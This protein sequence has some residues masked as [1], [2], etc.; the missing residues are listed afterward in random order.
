MKNTLAFALSA[1]RAIPAIPAIFA[2]AMLSTAHAAPGDKVVTF[3]GNLKADKI[4][5][6]NKIHVDCAI[7]DQ[8][9]GVLAGLGQYIGTAGADG[10]FVG[11][12][13]VALTVPAAVLATN[14]KITGWRCI[15][16]QSPPGGGTSSVPGGSTPLVQGTF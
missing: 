13:T 10:G 3:T 12:Y 6:G 8:A 16:L 5:P 15:V 14:P 4:Q 1:I 7:R 9:N 11:P 2:A